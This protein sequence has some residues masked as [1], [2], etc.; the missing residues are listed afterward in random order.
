MHSTAEPDFV[1]SSRVALVAFS[2]TD[3]AAL[4]PAAEL[5][6]RFQVAVQRTVA[7]APLGGIPDFAGLDLEQVQLVIVAASQSSQV[8]ALAAALTAP[9]IRVPLALDGSQA[10]ALEALT[11]NGG[12][13]P[14]TGSFATVALGDAGAR[15][16][17]LLAVSILALTDP[18]LRA[19]WQVFR[20]EQTSAVLAEPPPRG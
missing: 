2:E 10:A 3:L 1:S 6:G 14:G 11:A 12:A 8:R 13:D 16:A 7:A 4:S 19:A 5:L 9:V 15:N 17:A 18:R 20:D